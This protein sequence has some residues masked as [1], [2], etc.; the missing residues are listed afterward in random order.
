MSE[1]N[2]GCVSPDNV[3]LINSKQLSLTVLNNAKT[4]K[5]PG[6]SRGIGARNSMSC[7]STKAA[8][9]MSVCACMLVY[10]CVSVSRC[11]CVCMSVCLCLYVGISVRQ[12]VS[13]FVCLYVCISVSACMPVCLYICVFACLHHC[14]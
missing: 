7:Q 14:M 9:Y 4:N 12:C 1:K 2:L 6:N 8:V 3:H 5:N 11:V 13:L 10:L